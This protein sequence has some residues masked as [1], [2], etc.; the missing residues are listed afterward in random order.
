MKQEIAL[1]KSDCQY[2]Y[3]PFPNGKTFISHDRDTFFQVFR[4]TFYYRVT[5]T[6]WVHMTLA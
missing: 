3:I 2:S 6:H 4:E 1:K 5:C